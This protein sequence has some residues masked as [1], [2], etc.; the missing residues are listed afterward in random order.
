MEWIV[1]AGYDNPADA[2]DGV[3]RKRGSNFNLAENGD[4]EFYKKYFSIFF[5]FLFFRFL[6]DCAPKG[7]KSEENGIYLGG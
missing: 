6:A 5:C 4:L 2:A 1:L 7:G 3:R